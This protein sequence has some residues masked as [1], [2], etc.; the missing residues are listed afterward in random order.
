MN[1][2]IYQKTVAV[3]LFIIAASQIVSGEMPERSYVVE[4]ATE[5]FIVKSGLNGNTVYENKDASIAI[6]W[7]VN[8]INA[9]EFEGGEVLLEEGV[10]PLTNCIVIGDNTWLHGRGKDTKLITTTRI[11]E[12]LIVQDASMSVISDLSLE[13]RS[14][15]ERSTGVQVERCVN[16]QVIDLYVSGFNNGIVNDF[17]SSLTLI[18]GNT[19]D[20]NQTGINIKNGGGVIARWLPILVTQN[21]VSGGET[22]INCNALCTVINNNNISN[23]S[24]RGI[25]ANHNS[26]LVRENSISNVNGDFAIW[27]NRQEFNCT[28]NLIMNA[29][30]GGIRTTTRWG[31][32]TNNTIK[33]YGL[34]GNPSIGILIENDNNRK[35]GIAESKVVYNNIVTNDNP[36]YL[37]EYGIQEEGVS[38][39]IMGNMLKNLLFKKEAILSTGKGTVVMEN[40]VK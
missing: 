26:I 12:T 8:R 10:Y 37:L 39:V 31:T 9:G 11:R 3:C 5:R 17:E 40:L 25:V 14:G 6:Q 34:S 19:L 2:T 29:K 28:D 24:G 7:A 1:I 20:N 32:I 21:T 33:N 15:Y 16:C 35:E 13:N 27:G 38:N 23:T 22:G 36:E 18:N 4:P 30:G